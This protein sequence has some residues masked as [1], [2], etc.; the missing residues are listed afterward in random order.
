MVQMHTIPLAA[1]APRTSTQAL[2]G[3]ADPQ[4]CGS[5]ARWGGWVQAKPCPPAGLAAGALR[6]R[7][8][9]HANLLFLVLDACGAMFRPSLRDWSSFVCVCVCVFPRRELLLFRYK[10]SQQ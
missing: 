1:A 4:P 7:P 5:E 6:P 3:H 8:G 10:G 2:K 9:M